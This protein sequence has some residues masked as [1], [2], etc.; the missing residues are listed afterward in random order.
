[1]RLTETLNDTG[2]ARALPLVPRERR[3]A[4]PAV[5]RF[6]AKSRLVGRRLQKGLEVL[7]LLVGVPILLAHL[8]GFLVF[9]WFISRASLATYR[10]WVLRYSTGL[11]ALL[12]RLWGLTIIMDPVPQA[13]CGSRPII[14][15]AN[16]F[17]PVDI[18][19]MQVCFGERHPRFVA[20]PGMDRVPLFGYWLSHGGGVSLKHRDRAGNVALLR[21]AGAELRDGVGVCI[22]AEGRKDTRHYQNLLNFRT[23][24]VS[25]LLEGAPDALIVPV[26]IE[27]TNRFHVGDASLPRRGVRIRLTPLPPIDPRTFGGTREELVA[28]CERRIRHAL[29]DFSGPVAQISLD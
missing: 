11:V 16:H 7:T 14:I 22:F 15:V 25:A 27:G 1:M 18:P 20:R 5:L 21:Q 6:R 13:A 3:L 9:Q 12:R 10:R 28:D 17:S 23:L 2:P 29:G 19:L 24:G 4:A 26:A 8:L